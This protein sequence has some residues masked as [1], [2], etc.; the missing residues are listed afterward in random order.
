[1]IEIEI[2]E[3]KFKEIITRE[4]FNTGFYVNPE[5]VK[6][7]IIRDE[8]RYIRTNTLKDNKFFQWINEEDL[9]NPP[10]W[11]IFFGLVQENKKKPVNII[12][13]VFPVI[14]SPIRVRK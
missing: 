11:A 10:S 2:K 8:P 6:I 13:K 1:M 5:R 9:E 12:E 3:S 7:T 4:I 14:G